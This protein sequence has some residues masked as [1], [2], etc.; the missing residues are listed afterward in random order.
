MLKLPRNADLRPAKCA[1]ALALLFVAF[2]AS[3]ASAA[4]PPRIAPPSPDVPQPVEHASINAGP[5][6][7]NT[8]TYGYGA[9]PAAVVIKVEVFNNYLGDFTKYHWV[10]TVTNNSFDPFPPISNGFSGFELA[11]PAFVPDIADISAPDGIPPWLINCCSGLPVEWDLTNTLG[12]PVAGGT[13]PGETE[14]YSFTTSPRLVTLSTGWFHTWYTD[15]QVAIVNYPSGDGPEVPDVLSPPGQELCC[16]LDAAGA[17]VCET[18]PA[19]ECDLIHGVVVPSCTQ[20]PPP[21]PT[22]PSTWG[23]IK[24]RYR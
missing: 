23:S 21:V 5:I 16:H 1:A 14:V 6:F 24:N 10:Y 3:V 4:Y 22:K 12:A 18:L 17:Y 8:H 13:M 9:D 11:L 20:C 15:S 2:A 19:G 7:S